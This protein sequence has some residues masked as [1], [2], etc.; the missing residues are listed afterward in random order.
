MTKPFTPIHAVATVTLRGWCWPLLQP[1]FWHCVRAVKEPQ[2]AI[3]NSSG[4][5][6]SPY[7]APIT[8]TGP[9][10]RGVHRIGSLLIF[11][12]VHF[13]IWRHNLESA[14]MSWFTQCKSPPKHC[15]TTGVFL[16]LC[17]LSILPCCQLSWFIVTL[18]IF[19][20][21]LRA[22]D[23]DYPGVSALIC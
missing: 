1:L 18:A 19:G 12:L 16:F 22:P 6:V 4:A 15:L 9:S 3:Q 14:P 7:A 5:R 11:L 23:I 13:R 2:Q 21:F 8:P 17:L 20:V 10:I